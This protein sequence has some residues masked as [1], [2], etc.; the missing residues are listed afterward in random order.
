MNDNSN[1]KY[2]SNNYLPKYNSLKLDNK[3]INRF[4]KLQ[5]YHKSFTYNKSSN[6]SQSFSNIKTIIKKDNLDFV[7]IKKNPQTKNA[8]H[9]ISKRNDSSDINSKQKIIETSSISLLNATNPNQNRIIISS[10]N[11]D[12]DNNTPQSNAEKM[13]GPNIFSKLNKIN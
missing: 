9:I 1:N 7:K 3:Y 2:I 13:I 10:S 11:N 4:E 5:G 6:E 12:I 8:E